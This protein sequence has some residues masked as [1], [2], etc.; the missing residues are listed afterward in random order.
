MPV[1]S[2]S[3]TSDVYNLQRFVE[4]QEPVFANVLSELRRGRK[5]GHWIWFIFPQLR[6]L[7]RSFNSEFYGILS[8]AEAEA[9]VQHSLLG[10]RLI[11]CTELVNAVNGNNAEEIFGGIDVMKFRSSMSL[12]AKVSPETRAFSVALKKYFAGQF[13]P[14]TIAHLEENTAE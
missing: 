7:G 14:L 1:P 9:Y 6:G 3:A 2:M 5:Y 8:L 13:D 4:A 12:F 10:P 11:Q